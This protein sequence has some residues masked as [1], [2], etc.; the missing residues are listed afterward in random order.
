MDRKIVHGFTLVEVVVVIA[1]MAILLGVGIPSFMK[2]KARYDVESDTNNIFLLLNQAR[3]KSFF[4]KRMCGIVWNSIPITSIYLACDTDGDEKID[5]S[6][7][8]AVIYDT[9]NLT[10]SFNVNNVLYRYLR[11]FKTGTA[12][13]WGRIF[14]SLASPSAKYDCVVVSAIRI[15]KGHWDGNTCNPQ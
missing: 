8:G 2:W 9:L 5:D 14:Y 13:D 3:R 7:S 4:E 1:I 11:F 12:K 6:P 10:T 15:N